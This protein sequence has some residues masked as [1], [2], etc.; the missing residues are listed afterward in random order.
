MVLGSGAPV[1]LYQIGS[2]ETRVLVDVPANTPTASVAQGGVKGHLRRHVLPAL[3][4]SVQ[5]SFDAA[6]AR[7]ERLASSTLH[8][9]D[10]PS[11][12]SS[13]SAALRSMPN[14]FLPSTTNITP[15]L[16]LLGDALNM[17][18]PLT[19][20]GMTVAFND[21]VLLSSLLDP[22]R[23]NATVPL[24]LSD[25]RA[26][27]H[28]LR[29]FHWRRK[30]LAGVINILAQALYSLFA[31]NDAG[32]RALQM[33]CFRYFQLGGVCVS[34]PTGL[35]G[36]LIRRPMVLIGHFFAVAVYTIWL[37]LVGR[38]KVE[39]KT[40]KDKGMNGYANGHA[41][42]TAVSNEGSPEEAIKTKPRRQKE[43]PLSVLVHLPI[44]L[45]FGVSIFYK[46]CV[47]IF[48]YIL[49]ELRS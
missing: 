47:V 29:V 5:P 7:A 31:A 18:H 11:N 13:A 9:N 36:G 32:L 41:N 30:R 2:R 15:G 37:C 17:R 27:L 35:L 28:A 24:D 34:G 14:S 38:D 4:E 42:G 6:L 48:P 22:P 26:V 3:P 25:T 20:G 23:P 19:G 49:A 40:T 16:C 46:A 39:D 33:G 12:T 21:V 43:R 45:L 8:T 1:L 10:V 44:R